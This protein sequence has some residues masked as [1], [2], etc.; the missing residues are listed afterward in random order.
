M[1]LVNARDWVAFPAGDNSNDTL[2]GGTHFNLATLQ[3]WNYTFYSNNTV[4]N[5]SRCILV[6][7]PYTPPLL[8]ENG[9]FVNSSSC[10]SPINP[11]KTRSQ[12]G[13]FF[14]CFFALAV[15]FTSINLRKHGKLFLPTEKRFRAV[16]R[17][18]QWY[19]MF[20]VAAFGIISGITGVDVDRYYLPELPIVLSNF[21]WFLMLPTTMCVVWESV[22][23]WGS[24]QERQM[25]DPNPFIL[26]QDDQRAKFELYIPVIF[27]L[28]AFM[29]FFMMIPRSWSAIELQRD[30]D[31]ARLRAEPVATDIRFKLAALFLLW[32]WITTVLS[33]WH[34]IKHYKERNRGILNR[35][36]GFVRYAPKK[37]I[38]S[39]ILS[40][41]MI[42]YEAAI[43]FEFSISPLKLDTDVGFMY[44]L[45]WAPIA[46]IFIVLNVAGYI[47]PNEDKELIRQRRIR[48][49]EIDQEIG[50]VKK[51]HWW[52]RLNRDNQHMS[53][54][55]EIAHN[56]NQVGGGQPTA[57]NLETNIE[58][59]LMPASKGVDSNKPVAND[60]SLRM[61]SNLLFPAR[62]DIQETQERFTDH[63][64]P[65]RG[66][67]PKPRD[68][69]DR[70]D[71]TASGVTL[72]AKPQQ[73]RSMLDV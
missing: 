46:L 53:V 29:N 18:W 36:I 37:F 33:L 72:G 4:S 9:T 14:T 3:H 25:V 70:S 8:L 30:P 64:E 2:I 17:R 11:M 71:S 63:P 44:G 66:R 38:L 13:L 10:Y 49:A 67:D 31:Q 34:S 61:A 47:D 40:L 45:G 48:G 50:I 19:W 43:S 6:F 1:N 65:L 42:G 58:M 60:G 55:D 16:G 51:P 5:G 54:R 7:E 35:T 56:F 62:N 26:R 39:L 57:R 32:S 12:V 23:H 27:Y 28:F 68:V 22:R 20:I 73:I 41:V 59:G 21:F 24:W 69:S 15:V 52:S